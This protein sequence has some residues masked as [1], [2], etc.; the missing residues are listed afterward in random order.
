MF[1]KRLCKDQ[2]YHDKYTELMTDL[3]DNGFAEVVAAKD[4]GV[5]SGNQAITQTS[6]TLSHNNNTKPNDK[7]HIKPSHTI[8]YTHKKNQQQIQAKVISRTGK[9]NG[10]NKNWYNIKI[11]EPADL[12]GEELSVDLGQISNLNK[13]CNHQSACQWW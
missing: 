2:L 8:S 5:Q 10:K 13:K 6:S 11:M 7:I 12:A 1:E 9:A 3:I 4:I